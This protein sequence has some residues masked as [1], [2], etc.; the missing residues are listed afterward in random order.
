MFGSWLFGIKGGHKNLLYMGVS[1]LCWAFW[2]CRNDIVF[3]NVKKQTGL[4][5]LFRATHLVRTWAILHKEEDR[6]AISAACRALESTAMEIFAR[7]G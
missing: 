2:L 1:V 5:I 4:Q 6:D 7:H 3:D